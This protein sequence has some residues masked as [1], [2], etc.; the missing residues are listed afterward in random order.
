LQQF[1]VSLATN[2]LGFHSSEVPDHGL[3]HIL[4]TEGCSLEKEDCVT[5]SEASGHMQQPNWQQ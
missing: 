1:S 2:F 5:N 3:S 4:P